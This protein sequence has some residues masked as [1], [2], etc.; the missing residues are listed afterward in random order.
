MKIVKVFLYMCGVAIVKTATERLRQFVQLPGTSCSNIP[1]SEQQVPSPGYCAA[2]CEHTTL[3]Q[4]F[5]L[6]QTQPYVCW[7]L[8]PDTVND[9]LP[10]SSTQLYLSAYWCG[11]E[12]FLCQLYGCTWSGY[13]TAETVTCYHFFSDNSYTRDESHQRCRDSGMFLAQL[14]TDEE[15]EHVKSFLFPWSRDRIAAL[16]HQ[17]HLALNRIGSTGDYQWGTGAVCTSNWQVGQPDCHTKSTDPS[18]ACGKLTIPHWDPTRFDEFGY[19][20][21]FCTLD[22]KVMDYPLCELIL[23]ITCSTNKT[24]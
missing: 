24:N 20:D 17:F 14:E 3:C 9:C 22:S 1:L 23:P 4:A 6:S 18:C 10:N 12:T 13:R 8:N 11:L 2:L 19:D 21:S 7:L 16:P 15:F 5:T